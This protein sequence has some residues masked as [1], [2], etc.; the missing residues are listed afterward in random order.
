MASPSVTQTAVGVEPVTSVQPSTGRTA[1]SL[2]GR[3]AVLALL[4]FVF[5]FPLVFMIMSSLKPQAQI[6]ADMR[7][8][9]AFLPVGDIS[10][11]NYVDVFTNSQFPRFLINSVGLCAVQIVLGLFV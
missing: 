11:D 6:F 10:L 9:A 8:F 7:S 3:Y 2:V 4:M 5:V 1:L